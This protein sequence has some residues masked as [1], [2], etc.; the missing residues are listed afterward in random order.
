MWTPPSMRTDPPAGASGAPFPGFSAPLLGHG[1]RFGGP[2]GRGVLR[3][4]RYP[5]K[6]RGCGDLRR[7][8]NR[9]EAKSRASA[10]VWQARALAAPGALQAAGCVSRGG[11]RRRGDGPRA[12]VP[13]ASRAPCAGA[14]W[15]G[16]RLPAPLVP[17]SSRGENWGKK[18]EI[19]PQNSFETQPFGCQSWRSWLTEML[20]GWG[21]PPGTPGSAVGGGKLRHGWR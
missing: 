18:R 21:T 6:P 13:P 16:P 1:A 9:F 2:H 3:L 10:G 11:F 14:G 17:A 4:V 7:G 19:L 5:P 8:K 15:Q 20:R 12:A